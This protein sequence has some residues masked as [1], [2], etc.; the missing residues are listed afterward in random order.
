MTNCFI[1]GMVN[2]NL[3]ASKQIKLTNNLYT[4]KYNGVQTFEYNRQEHENI[5]YI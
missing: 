2:N 3:Y 1:I 4:K 5:Q